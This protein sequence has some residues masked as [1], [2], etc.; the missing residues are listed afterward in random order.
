MKRKNLSFDSCVVQNLIHEQQMVL[1]E[2]LDKVD[3]CL[4]FLKVQGW[5]STFSRPESKVALTLITEF[6][7]IEWPSISYVQGKVNGILFRITASD[8]SEFLRLPNVGTSF[9][10]KM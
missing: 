9:I 8:I 1:D 4:G 2:Y 7:S 5:L 6:N 10:L 3:G